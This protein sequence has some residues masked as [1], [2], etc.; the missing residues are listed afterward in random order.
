VRRAPAVPAKI[1]VPRP[2]DS[3]VRPRLHRALDRA[4]KGRAIWVT[5]AAGAGKTTLVAG[6]LAE[7]RVPCLWYHADAGDADVAGLFYYL[8]RAVGGRGRRRRRAP[9]PLLT[10]E[11]AGGLAVFTRRYFEALFETLPIGAVMVFDNDQD[12]GENAVWHE[13]LAQA[14]ASVPEASTMI[15]VSRREPPAVFAAAIAQGA[16]TVV[17]GQEL[18]F[19][20]RE[21]TALIRAR[22]PER[23]LSSGEIAR[24]ATEARGWAAGLI[25]LIG[26]ASLD[27]R[28]S[29][30]RDDD[31]TQRIFD[32]FATEVFAR[33]PPERQKFLLSTALLPALTGSM[34]AELTGAGD[35][36]RILA[37]FNRQGF[38]IQRHAAN[39]DVY[40]YHPLFRAFLLERG[41]TALSPTEQMSLR[42]KAAALLLQHDQFE[43]AV[44]LFHDAADGDGLTQ[45]IL[46]QAPALMEQGRTATLEAWLGKLDPGLVDG[47]SWLTYWKGAAELARAAPDCLARFEQALAG[48][49][50]QREGAGIFLS[51]AGLLQAIS[52]QGQDFGRL[53]RI[54]REVD[55]ARRAGTYPSPM[56]ALQVASAMLMALTYRCPDGLDAG[57]W[58]DEALELARGC[59][60][61]APKVNI[62]GMA[63]FFYAIHGHLAEAA[64]VRHALRLALTSHASPTMVASAKGG[65]AFL[66]LLSGDL[67]ASEQAADDGLRICHHYGATIFH[68]SL[69]AMKAQR[70]LY[71]GDDLGAAPHLEMVAR[72]AAAV[73]NN[74]HLGNSH[75][76]L[77]W[78]ALVRGDFHRASEELDLS[79][80]HSSQ[81][82][83]QVVDAAIHVARA[84]TLLELGREA[85][86]LTCLAAARAAAEPA[87]YEA[88]LFVCHLARADY[89]DR[90]GDRDQTC[91]AL[92]DA[93]A[94]GRRQGIVAAP[95][96]RPA[97]LAR[98]CA[99]ALEEGIEVDHA[100]TM[101]RK[102]GL[103]PVAAATDA[104]PWALRIYT[105]D[106]F[107]VVRRD[108]APQASVRLNGTPLRLLEALMAS[109]GEASQEEISDQLWPDADG[110]AARRVFDT[111]LHRLRRLLGDP[112]ALRLA[113]GRLA[114]D[115]QRC[116]ADVWEVE[117][118]VKQMSRWLDRPDPDRTREQMVQLGDRLCRLYGG[119]S[120]AS[121]RGG[122]G[123]VR[124]RRLHR[125]TVRALE[126][127]AAYWRR[128]GDG[129]RAR[130]IEQHLLQLANGAP[131][132]SAPARGTSRAP[133][134][135]RA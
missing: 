123:E 50:V 57:R 61:P 133:S 93:L 92:R 79:V 11:Y 74:Y 119:P 8:S 52:F 51:L 105:F 115:R 54:M 108:D 130:A 106:R 39:E 4:R 98:L 125:E 48:F 101:I 83:F 60:A 91:Q 113:D 80:K 109:G 26:G 111:T 2:S 58:L 68:S 63:L 12:V 126:E 30:A 19:T 131:G 69:L 65:E 43:D 94:L 104:W 14:V 66:L 120:F 55:E 1:S 78:A 5:G 44:E 85:D 47:N 59:P 45:I 90:R 13:V 31:A 25:L 110:D 117:S 33:L 114:L 96:T 9:L 21:A 40:R 15:F 37:L 10:P 17:G 75:Y 28:A 22:R 102:L 46:A 38:F 67:D 100:R 116:W 72:M 27:R 84:T 56:V 35:A 97:T 6:Y 32:Y 99:R 18:E 88:V 23:R 134:A 135:A 34:A 62:Y 42:R 53:D 24:F 95:W 70:A 71:A 3:V 103:P 118:I 82:G 36:G 16:M 7:K 124:A 86:I 129:A 77:G 107:E 112:Q 89:H 132:F 29:S 49:R 81:L 122:Q 127:A 76:H 41:T 87:H 73:G 128:S 64:K 20:A 121:T